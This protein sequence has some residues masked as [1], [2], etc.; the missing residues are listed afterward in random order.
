[1]NLLDCSLFKH[2]HQIRFALKSIK[3]RV[4]FFPFTFFW[5]KKMLVNVI[6][7]ATEQ[8]HLVRKYNVI[9]ICPPLLSYNT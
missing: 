7:V 1:M 8:K 9:M 4:V 2:T 3:R 5:K 6:S